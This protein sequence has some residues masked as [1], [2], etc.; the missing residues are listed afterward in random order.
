MEFLPSQKW[1]K[2]LVITCYAL[3]GALLVWVF[4]SKLFSVLLPFFAAWITA[5]LLQGPIKQL[6]ERVGRFHRV[7]S[8]LVTFTVL[9]VFLALIIMVINRLI[10][11]AANIVDTLGKSSEKV[12]EAMSGLLEDWKKRFPTLGKYTDENSVFEVVKGF[13]G[14]LTSYIAGFIASLLAVFPDVGLFCIVYV[15][16]TFYFA[17]DFKNINRAALSHLPDK[18]GNRIRKMFVGVKRSAADYF[19]AYMTIMLVTTAELFCGFLVLRVEYAFV[20]SLVIA[21]LDML[22][23]IG[24]GLVLVP[25]GVIEILIGNN[26]LGTG[27]LVLFGVISIIREIIEPRIVGKCIGLHPLLTLFS[28]YFGYRLFG[29]L[30]MLVMPPLAMLTKNLIRYNNTTNRA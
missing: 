24:T 15:I 12:I 30:G 7:L 8:F 22:P 10:Y 13:L 9:A 17:M 4:F 19:K 27:L 18:L 11:E 2:I 6:G 20:L 1:A 28:M 3:I 23:V 16:A 26:S 29:V 21:F 25:W 14:N 5:F